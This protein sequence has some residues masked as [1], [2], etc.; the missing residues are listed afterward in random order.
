MSTYSVSDVAAAAGAPASR[1]GKVNWTG[2]G[3][4]IVASLVWG[5][6]GFASLY[7]EDLGD[8][9]RTQAVGIAA[10]IVAA[11]LLIGTIGADFLGSSGAA[12][13]RRVPWFIALGAFATL[14]EVATA[15]FGWLPLPFFPPP[16]AI[17]EVYTDDVQK[18]ADSVFASVKLQLGGYLIGAVLGFITAS[19]SAGRKRSGTG[20]IRC[21][22]SS[23]R[24]RLPLGCR[25]R[26]SPSRRAGA[27]ARS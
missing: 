22:A 21:C 8:W 18:L 7:W 20:C 6:F 24:C 14:W 3:A 5:A 19:R 12:L 2:Y 10:L 26:S 1:I 17:I 16:Q 11:L 13:R 23:G 4:G 25:S 9:S 27:P 15:K